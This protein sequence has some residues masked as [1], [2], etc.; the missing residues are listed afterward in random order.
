M[1]HLPWG[2]SP[3]TCALAVTA[4]VAVLWGLSWWVTGTDRRFTS[5]IYSVL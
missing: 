2:T 1:C 3:P 5:E 4:V